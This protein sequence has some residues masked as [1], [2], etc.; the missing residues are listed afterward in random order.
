MT[1]DQTTAT[2]SLFRAAFALIVWGISGI[3]CATV[4]IDYA[5][6]ETTQGGWDYAYTGDTDA[7]A[8]KGILGS[9]DNTWTA[10]REWDGSA[11]GTGGGSGTGPAPGG[12]KSY[13]GSSTIFLRMQDPGDPSSYAGVGQTNWLDPS[14]RRYNLV[15]DLGSVVNFNTLGATISFRARLATTG[16]LDDQYI[17]A[18]GGTAAWPT[19]GRGSIVSQDAR[20]QFG[21]SLASQGS[22]GFSLAL[23]SD[24]SVAG[25][26]G[27]L[28]MNN[29]PT[30]VT[31]EVTN[32]TTDASQNNIVPLTDAELTGWHEFVIELLQAI[33]GNVKAKVYKSRLPA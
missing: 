21:I 17:E 32:A 2:V 27:G 15:H 3:A 7:F 20:A 33:G 10:K 1:N 16:T 26:G 25:V 13:S 22:F 23:D 30:S 6:V 8:G 9:L 29:N 18:G 11:P 12:I 4:S 24:T 19:G 28:V 5:A 14:N 31:G